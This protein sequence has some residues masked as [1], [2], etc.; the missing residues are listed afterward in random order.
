MHVR[1]RPGLWELGSLGLPVAGRP[2]QRP[3]Y[4]PGG[5]D[6]RAPGAFLDLAC[7]LS[8]GFSCPGRQQLS[9]QT[10]K[11]TEWCSWGKQDGLSVC[12]L[13]L[14]KLPLSVL[15]RMSCSHANGNT[16]CRDR[17]ACHSGNALRTRGAC[18]PG[19]AATGDTC[20]RPFAGAAVQVWPGLRAPGRH[21]CSR[22][23]VFPQPCVAAGSGVMAGGQSR[24]A[25][26][27]AHLKTRVFGY[28]STQ[29]MN[30][31]GQPA[32]D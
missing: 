28:C 2:V 3:L 32:S 20:L 15:F 18:G 10:V 26:L 1:L 12:H 27:G 7:G 6:P 9:T 25:A 17:H 8:C 21:R 31:K 30:S 24:R 16:K 11:R 19:P 5:Q 23:A 4:R 29:A 13:V 14:H 22:H